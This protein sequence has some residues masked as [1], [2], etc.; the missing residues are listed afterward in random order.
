MNAGPHRKE[1]I[2]TEALNR[3]LD[4]FEKTDIQTID[5]TGGTPEMHPDFQAL[6]QRVRG[7]DK[8]REIIT[9]LNAT[10]INEPGYEWIPEFHTRH[11]ITLI[12]SMPCYSADNVNAQRGDGVFD[13]SISAFQKL[14]ALGYGKSPD[15]K[16]HFVFNP[17][18]ASLPPSQEELSADY[19]KEM[20][21]HFG[22]VFNDLYCITNMPIARYASY[23]KREK[24]L[25][26]YQQLLVENFNP[27][28]I[29]GLMCR[30][31][32]SVDWEGGVF[33]C[34]FNQQLNMPIQND[35]TQKIWDIDLKKLATQ[36]IRTA[37]HCFGCTAGA[38]SSCGGSLV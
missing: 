37:A 18:G 25:A 8:K 13:S 14:N 10:I 6:V 3:T 33:D 26:A 12:A 22:I 32:I 21:K 1:L 23:L 17:V 30:D 2:T 35:S 29:E 31:T 36:E 11:Q 20:A 5:L 15:L 27:G 19:K 28:S 9:R 34:D 16:M 4:W 7:F 24:K 38:G